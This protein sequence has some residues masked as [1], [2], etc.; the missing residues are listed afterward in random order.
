MEQSVKNS[1]MIHAND[2]ITS[3]LTLNRRGW[4]SSTQRVRLFPRIFFYI[5]IIALLLIPVAIIT[6]FSAVYIINP[7][8]SFNAPELPTI[9]A[10]PEI[11]QN[12]ELLVAPC[13]AL[14]VIA[15]FLIFSIMAL[16]RIIQLFQYTILL[17]IGRVSQQ[18]GML[19]GKTDLSEN[20]ENG[21]DYLHRYYVMDGRHFRVSEAAYDALGDGGEFRVYYFPVHIIP[22]R[23]KRYYILLNL[24]AV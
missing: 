24:E 5:F 12:P 19:I 10:I 22:F 23:G 4:L 1:S 15:V 16:R 21:V 14:A 8:G 13:L 6:I 3:A 11:P 9:P 17:I 7:D 20:A 2:F 18:Q